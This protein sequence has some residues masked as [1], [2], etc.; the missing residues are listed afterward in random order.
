MRYTKVNP[1]SY[2][3]IPYDA[4]IL[5]DDFDPETGE[6]TPGDVLW[7]TTGSNTFNATREFTDMGE[8]INNVPEGTKQ[9]QKAKPWQAELSGTAISL[10][11]DDVVALLSSADKTTVSTSGSKI[12]PRNELLETDFV[13][14]WLICNYSDKTGEKKGGYFAIHIKNALST[15]GFSFTT[16]KEANG[17]TSY[18][19]KAFYDMN[20][21][22]EVPFDI[23]V[24]AGEDEAAAG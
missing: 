21:I 4:G 3:Q 19:Y 2:K 5:V 15:G 24:K 12:T 11:A 8:G 23:Y 18:T 7:L 13:G 10:S 1:E 22:D 6:I 17:E 20:N 16:N 14:K 9:L